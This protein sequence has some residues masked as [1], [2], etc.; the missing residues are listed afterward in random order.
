MS[1]KKLQVEL[2]LVEGFEFRVRFNDA[3]EELVM[4]EPPPLGE[5][6]GPNAARVLSA[7]IGNCLSASLLFCLQKSKIRPSGLKTAVSTAVERNDRG[8]LRIG[9]TSV[10]IHLALGD[11]ERDRVGRCMEVFEDYCIVTQSV[12]RGIEVDVTVLDQD[13]RELHRSQGETTPD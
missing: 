3:W 8:R 1:D 13:G 7:A 4:D 12:R 6:R 10:H 9:E 5:D 2:E 11:E